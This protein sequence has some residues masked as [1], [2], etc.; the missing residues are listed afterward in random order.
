MNSEK[1]LKPAL[2]Y[3]SIIGGILVLHSILLYIMN[4]SFSTYAQV[5]AYVLPIALLA[6]ALNSYRKEY[7]GGYLTYSKGVGMGVLFSV[8][9]SLIAL[10]YFIILIKVIDPGYLELMNRMVEEKL[11]AK[12]L[13]EDMIEST[14]KMT[15]RFR[16]PWILAI[17][18][19][20]GGIIM[21]TIYSLI[22]MIF[23]KKV[24]ANPFAN[25]QES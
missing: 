25:V 4:A 1:T 13:S 23:V 3:G 2:L 5:M 16:S 15:E 7:G 10:I 11:L 8:V 6:Y 22:I 9:S 12:G 14:M 19:F 21:G 24:P 18:S 17:S 20:L